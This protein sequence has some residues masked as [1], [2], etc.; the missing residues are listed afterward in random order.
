M[1]K[2]FYS[3]AIDYH[4][5]G[6]QPLG[7]LRIHKKM[8]SSSTSSSVGATVTFGKTLFPNEDT[9]IVI[10]R[11]GFSIL[12]HLDD[13]EILLWNNIPPSIGRLQSCKSY[14]YIYMCYLF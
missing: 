11:W 5:H 7:L 6:L 12:R 8:S 9:I 1:F 14:T 13:V 2:T 3:T 10:R 4:E